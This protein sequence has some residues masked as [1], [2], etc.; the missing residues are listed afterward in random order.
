MG[1]LIFQHTI[2]VEKVCSSDFLTYNYKSCF[3]PLEVKIKLKLNF[4]S[5]LNT[6]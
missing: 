6:L 2:V 5:L 3:K 4:F 1:L